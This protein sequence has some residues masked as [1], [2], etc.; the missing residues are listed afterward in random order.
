MQLKEIINKFEDFEE[1]MSKI[2][3]DLRNLNLDKIKEDIK[4]IFLLLK[5]KVDITG[6][7][8]R[9]NELVLMIKNANH[10]DN[11]GESKTNS[12]E[13]TMDVMK[14]IHIEEQFKMI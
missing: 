7:D 1:K 4:Q 3:K 5:E 6:L 13:S 12:H 2:Q 8:I 11:G 9:I 10:I 14:F